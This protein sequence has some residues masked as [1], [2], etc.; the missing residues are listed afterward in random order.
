MPLVAIPKLEEQEKYLQAAVSNAKT[1]ND[2]S[3]ANYRE[4]L[5]DYSAVIDVSR[6]VFN[7][8]NALA[9]VR[10]ARLLAVVSYCKAIGGTQ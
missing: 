8:T 7:A 10:P 5:T 6:T 4:G 3:F 1:A 9:D 2:M